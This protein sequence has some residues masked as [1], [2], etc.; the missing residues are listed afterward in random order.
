MFRRP[1][2]RITWG[3]WD[4]YL[5]ALEEVPDAEQDDCID[6]LEAEWSRLRTWAC[7]APGGVLRKRWGVDKIPQPTSD[8]EVVV[9]TGVQES[10]VASTGV[11][12]SELMEE[13]PAPCVYEVHPDVPA[14][15]RKAMDCVVG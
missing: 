11:Q 5:E 12:E 7:F 15:V 3:D 6:R 8:P 4:R 10:V 14:E 2:G 9:A 13:E 1:P